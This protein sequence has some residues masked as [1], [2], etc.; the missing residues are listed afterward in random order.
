MSSGFRSLPPADL[1][2]AIEELLL[3]R[4]AGSLREKGPGHCMRVTRV[5]VGGTSVFVGT[6]SLNIGPPGS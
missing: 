4:L 3:P 5:H 1:T 2:R 6:G